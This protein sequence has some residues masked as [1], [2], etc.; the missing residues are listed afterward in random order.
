MLKYFRHI[1]FD[2]L[3]KLISLFFKVATRKLKITFVAHIIFG[4]DSTL[5][6]CFPLTEHKCRKL[7]ARVGEK[8][9]I[10]PITNS[11]IPG[12]P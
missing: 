6:K 7:V 8:V 9:L 10:A 1:R 5:L 12:P 4:L 11:F 3:L 2:M